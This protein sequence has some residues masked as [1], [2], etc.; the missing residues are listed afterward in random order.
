MGL[1]RD[2]QGDFSIIG[3]T[4]TRV[5]DS[6][7]PDNLK[8]SNYNA[9]ETPREGNCGGSLLYVS[10][11]MDTIHRPGLEKL[12]Y[13]SKLLETSFV[14]ISREKQKNIVVGCI[15]RHHGLTIKDF[16]KSFINPLL[17]KINSEN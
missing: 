7:L 3:I 1:L 5:C 9:F 11:D 16:I 10:K 17:T 12:M 13:R 6:Q 8:I 2:L 15:Y 4:E 14:E